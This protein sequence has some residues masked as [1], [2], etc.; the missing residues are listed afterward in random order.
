MKIEKESFDVNYLL[1]LSRLP[2]RFFEM[3][4]VKQIDEAIKNSTSEKKPSENW[5]NPGSSLRSYLV[6]SGLRNDSVILEGEPLQN[7]RICE[8][9]SNS[10]SVLRTINE[11]MVHS[12][13][14]LTTQLTT[15]PLAIRTQFLSD[16]MDLHNISKMLQMSF[17]A[18][19][20]CHETDDDKIDTLTGP[21]KTYRQSLFDMQD[22]IDNITEKLN[23]LP[24]DEPNPPQYA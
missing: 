24:A 6:F 2:D 11:A 16:I 8:K 7:A 10:V 3:V 17:D 20:S 12:A 13:T 15:M 4:F 18:L 14:V 22:I 19:M 5:F 21:G 9:F 1:S 23:E